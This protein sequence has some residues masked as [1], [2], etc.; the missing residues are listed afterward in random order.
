MLLRKENCNVLAEDND[1]M[2]ALHIASQ[3]GHTKVAGLLLD[4]GTEVD[5]KNAEGNTPLNLAVKAK[6]IETSRLLLSK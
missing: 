3:N 5:H 4:R 2:T 6:C 1:G